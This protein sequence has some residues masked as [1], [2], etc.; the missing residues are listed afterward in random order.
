[1]RFFDIL[2]V[3]DF[4]FGGGTSTAVAN[5]LRALS[6]TSRSVGLYQ[7]DAD[8][9][10]RNA[11]PWHPEIIRI[12][13]AVGATIIV[14]GEEAQANI[15]IVHSPWVFGSPPEITPRLRARLRLLIAH[16]PP[17]NAKGLLYYDPWTVHR[18]ARHLFGGEFIWA[19]NSPVCRANFAS[20]G[21]HLPLL[22]DDWTNVIF[23]DD[24]GEARTQPRGD[25]PIIGR[26]SQARV[27]KWPE[28]RADILRAYPPDPRI[29]VRVMGI[30]RRVRRILGPIPSNWMVFEVNSTPVRNFLAEIDFFVYFH[31]SSWVE[32]FGR[33]IA[34]AA[35]AG[36]IV[37]I[38]H[39]LEANFG[40]AAV[41]G[42]VSDVDRIVEEF[43]TD[44]SAFVSQSLR[45]RR[46]IAARYSDQRLLETLSRLE[47][48][49]PTLETV[50]T[51][52]SLRN[53]WDRARYRLRGS[54]RKRV[55][56]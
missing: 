54:A 4:R 12:I 53:L 25:L 37:V 35:S 8:I 52:H 21:V 46:E 18:R 41:Y 28:Q 40:A 23:V 31:H 30:P 32:S 16:H 33:C 29:K 39:Y 15:L 43:W 2:L 5:E 51:Y 13:K 27:T 50:G 6:S 26:H 17:M 38:P 34:E 11:G 45:A 48:M 22:K 7:L 1:M 20:A 3:G 55:R 56:P 24:W 36:C 49:P 42:D 9:V 44:R 10:A 14:P 19:P 47:C